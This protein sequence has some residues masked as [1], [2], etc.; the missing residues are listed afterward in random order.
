MDEGDNPTVAFE[1]PYRQPG[2][3]P[4]Q[5]RISEDDATGGAAPG[6]LA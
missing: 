6:T 5:G 4:P 1:E 3:L 2:S